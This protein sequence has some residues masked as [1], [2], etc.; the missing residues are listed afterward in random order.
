MDAATNWAYPLVLRSHVFGKPADWRN[1]TN[2]RC[3][4]TAFSVLKAFHK[5]LALKEVPGGQGT[6]GWDTVLQVPYVSA[7]PY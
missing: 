1:N 3:F 6:C 2:L 5:S 7:H 4:Y